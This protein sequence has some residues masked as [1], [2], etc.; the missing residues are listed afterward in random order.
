[1]TPA[2]PPSP[3]AAY[4]PGE[5]QRELAVPDEIMARLE[6]YAAMLHKWQPKINLIS[7]RSLADLWRRHMLDSAQLRD[8]L[9]QVPGPWLDI[10]SGAGFPGLVL[11]LLQDQNTV[12]TVHLIESDQRKCV[13]LNEVIRLTQAPAQVHIGRIEHLSPGLFGGK[14][15]LITARALAPLH[16]LFEFVSAVTQPSTVYLL[17][18]GQ[19][20]DD[21]LTEAAKYRTMTVNQYPSRTHPAGRVLRITEVA[22]V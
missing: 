18:K 19:D 12:Q 3:E 10:G 14:A 11:A 7:Q 2:A 16:Q 5:F 20:V 17:L 8:Y 22:R 9:A 21:E 6:I 4:G 15:G 13:F 1:M